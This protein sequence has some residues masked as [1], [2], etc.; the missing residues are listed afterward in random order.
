V[1]KQTQNKLTTESAQNGARS[2]QVRTNPVRLQSILEESLP[3]T[4][5][6]TIRKLFKK[7]TQN[8]KITSYD[9]EREYYMIGY[10]DG[11]SE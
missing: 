9:K 11:D 10:E 7:R 6:T 3:H 1:R 8:G 5:G 4:V 2:R